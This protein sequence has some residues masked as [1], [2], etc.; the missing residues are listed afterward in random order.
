[1]RRF[2]AVCLLM[3]ILAALS[4]RLAADDGC[5]PEVRG[6][7]G[8]LSDSDASPALGSAHADGG[9]LLVTADGV[10]EKFALSDAGD[11]VMAERRYTEGYP[12][13][14]AA[15][16]DRIYVDSVGVGYEVLRRSDLA[17]LGSLPDSRMSNGGAFDVAGDL[18]VRIEGRFVRVFEILSDSDFVE[19]GSIEV[20]GAV[21]VATDGPFAYV[22]TTGTAE[23]VV[24]DLADP[25]APVIAGRV[26]LGGELPQ[27]PRLR[28]ARG[29]VLTATKS[30]LLLVDVSSPSL[31]RIASRVSRNQAT[32]F[33]TDGTLAVVADAD[34]L[35]VVDLRSP[36]DP[37]VAATLASP[38]TYFRPTVLVGSIAVLYRFPSPHL[39]AVGSCRSGEPPT[40]ARF[41][42]GPVQATAGRK[43]RF[44]D[45]STGRDLPRRWSFGDGTSATGEHPVHSF[46]AAGTYVVRLEVGSGASVAIRESTVVVTSDAP[47]VA[48]FTMAQIEDE[49]HFASYRLVDTSAGAV[50]DRLWSFGE[51]VTIGT[52]A[53]LVR[54]F[55]ADDTRVVTLTVRSA[56]G[57]SSASRSLYPTAQPACRPEF[58]GGIP[59]RD[60]VPQIE[61]LGPGLLLLV[62]SNGRLRTVDVSEPRAPRSLAVTPPPTTW[63][64]SQQVAVAGRFVYASRDSGTEI[65][66][67][68]DPAAPRLRAHLERPALASLLAEGDRLYAVGADGVTVWNIE[69]RVHPVLV[70]ES[71]AGRDGWTTRLRL[72]RGF[73]Y[74][75]NGDVRLIDV[76]RPEL[77]VVRGRV[78]TNGCC[79]GG[80]MELV[81]QRLLDSAG[82]TLQ[83]VRT[84]D[85]RAPRTWGLRSFESRLDHLAAGNGIA[86][87]SGDW[88][89]WRFPLQVLDPDHSSYP[90][91]V[92]PAVGY[93][94]LAAVDGILWAV[95]FRGLGGWKLDGCAT[96]ESEPWPEISF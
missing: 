43:V 65:F 76:T 36:V 37:I 87:V 84:T 50:T 72:D 73:L 85:P 64:S 59:F 5:R 18:L 75:Y 79:W 31:P 70:G 16:D 94:G 56:S 92:V 9:F 30:E 35:S 86:L 17:R 88:Y 42:F 49:N 12:W 44:R 21:Q 1:M 66:D 8:G 69:D 27:D 48:D 39:V 23:L 68:A 63:V 34:G 83:E 29:H 2:P 6:E 52:D 77:P 24:L 47:P 10:V 57:E 95:G 22:L 20:E 41:D 15:D 96:I 14:S 33:D 28:I 55:P 58:L 91:G 26:P 61:S 89:S 90:L 32:S 93:S 80:D 4:A 7:L 19:R 74:A 81:G 51:N 11:A 46:A 40:E 67:F 82:S 78:A 60:D 3:P 54:T 53:S 62:S 45:L 25:S 38:S 71:G 13:R